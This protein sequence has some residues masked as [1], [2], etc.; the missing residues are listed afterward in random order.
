MLHTQTFC[1]LGPSEPKFPAYLK[2]CPWKIFSNFGNPA[3]IVSLFWFLIPSVPL[4][5]QSHMLFLSLPAAVQW[6][7]SLNDFST[8]ALSQDQCAG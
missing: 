6:A 5:A 1:G 8:I 4:L 7:D 2:N 3:V